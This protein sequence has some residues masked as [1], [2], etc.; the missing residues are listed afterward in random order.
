MKLTVSDIVILVDV[1]SGS[2]RLQDNGQLF[3]TTE[4]VRKELL[5]KILIQAQQQE[6]PDVLQNNRENAERAK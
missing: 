4:L 1:L 3:R 6:L 2:L 5:D